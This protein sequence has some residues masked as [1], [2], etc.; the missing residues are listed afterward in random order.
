[1]ALRDLIGSDGI[2]SLIRKSLTKL[3]S[4]G[5]NRINEPEKFEEIEVETKKEITKLKRSKTK[6]DRDNAADDVLDKF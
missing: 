2:L 3:I 1:M 6:E 5:K 4:F